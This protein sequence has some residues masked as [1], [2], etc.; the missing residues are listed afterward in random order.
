MKNSKPINTPLRHN[1]G[2]R[3]RLLFLVWHGFWFL[4]LLSILALLWLP[5]IQLHNRSILA[6]SG[7]CAT[8]AALMLVYSLRPRGWTNTNFTPKNS[9]RISRES[10]QPLYKILQQL[11]RTLN[12]SAP[13][14][15]KI[16][17]KNCVT[18][19]ATRHWNGKIKSLQVGIGLPLFGTLSEEELSSLIAHE[20]AQFFSGSVPL[21]PFVYRT[22]LRLSN[23]ITDLDNSVYILDIIF[24]S[25]AR[26][27]LHLRR[28]PVRAKPDATNVEKG[29]RSYERLYPKHRMSCPNL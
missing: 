19:E 1:I 29:A 26:L 14:T 24:R 5:F 23:A 17:D 13:A 3:C 10:F 4:V 20:F 2:G 28:T 16:T 21:A 8:L 9:S 22:R 18:I 12:V 15:I 7:F 27:F 6:F 25:F 11:G